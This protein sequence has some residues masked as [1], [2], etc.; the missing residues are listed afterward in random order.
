MKEIPKTMKRPS[1]DD[2]KLW[3]D[4]MIHSEIEYGVLEVEMIESFEIRVISHG[5]SLRVMTYYLEECIL[6]YEYDNDGHKIKSN[7]VEI[8]KS[9]EKILNQIRHFE[10]VLP[11]INSDKPV[12]ETFYV[13]SIDGITIRANVIKQDLYVEF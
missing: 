11:D 7:Q 3:E 2:M 10:R 1:A 5:Q 8:N 9:M 6:L 13:N 12:T 4:R